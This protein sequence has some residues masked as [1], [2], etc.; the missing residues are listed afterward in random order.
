MTI[1]KDAKDILTNVMLR[2]PFKKARA[3]LWMHINKASLGVLWKE[4]NQRIFLN[5]EHSSI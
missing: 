1:P 4:R 3:L 5:K 2:D